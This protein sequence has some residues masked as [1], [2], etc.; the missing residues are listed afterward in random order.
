MSLLN[1]DTTINTYLEIINKN[2]LEPYLTRTDWGAIEGTYSYVD[3]IDA[4]FDSTAKTIRSGIGTNDVL[5]TKASSYETSNYFKIQQEST[6]K[7]AAITDTLNTDLDGSTSKSIDS[8]NLADNFNTDSDGLIYY[9]DITV[10]PNVKIYNLA[11]D[12]SFTSAVSSSSADPTS[13][14]D[15]AYYDYFVRFKVLKYINN[16]CFYDT[17][18]LLF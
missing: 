4:T 9:T 5:K 7:A 16:N 6:G 15:H 17:N 10:T 8:T 1:L 3:T 14:T 11:S 13:L 18:F 2:I 12:T